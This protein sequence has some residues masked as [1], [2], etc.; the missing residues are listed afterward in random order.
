M[1][2]RAQAGLPVMA[3][4]AWL[5]CAGCVVQEPPKT[6]DDA[7]QAQAQGQQTG[8]STD[9]APAAANGP[10]KN[11]DVV[12]LADGT[13]LVGVETQQVPGQYVVLVTAAG[14]EHT[15]PWTRIGPPACGAPMAPSAPPAAGAKKGVVTLKDGSKLAGT[16]E[17]VQPGQFVV[18]AT[19]DGLHHTIPWDRVSEVSVSGP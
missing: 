5:L 18:V 14:E 17:Q 4:T 10:A 13:Q 15:I 12:Q 8:A 19:G 16:L 2:A 11:V 6:P 1:R 9:K 3:A 7:T